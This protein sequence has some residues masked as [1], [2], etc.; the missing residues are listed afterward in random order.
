MVIALSGTKAD[1]GSKHRVEYGEAQVYEDENS[2]LFME[3]SAKTA[4]NVNYSFLA[5]A[6]K[7][8]E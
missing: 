2:L 6:K 7:L 3:T 4:M 8:P 5:T 1:P